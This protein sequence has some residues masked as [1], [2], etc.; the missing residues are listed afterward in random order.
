MQQSWATSGLDL[1]LDLPGTRVRAGLEAALREAV[2]SGRLA[3]GTRLPSSRTLAADLRIARNTVADAYGQLVAEGWLAARQG[4]GTVV[5]SAAWLPGTPAAATAPAA[6]PEAAG[7]PAS[8]IRYDLRA[9][10][11]DLSGFPR[12]AWLAAARKALNASPAQ[13]L[14]YSDPRGLPGLRA[15]LAVY[16][17]RA[18]GVRVAPDRILVCSGFTQGLGL[19]C[20]ALHQQGATSIAV[21]GYGQPGNLDI[22]AGNG[23]RPV[24]LPVD[25]DGAVPD[26]AGDAQAMLLT[27]AHQFPLGPALAARRRAQAARWATVTGGLI[28]EDD[29]DGEFR[30]DRQPVGA[31]QA[32]APEQVAYA[33][34]ASKTLA[35]GLRLGW[36]AL[37]ARIA[38]D[39]TAAKARADAH[40]SSVEQL[41]LAEFIDSGRY[42]RHI[43][44]SRLTYR[45]RRDRLV[46]ELARHA[47]AVRLTGVAAGLHV[48]AELPEGRSESQVTGRAAR[49]GLAVEGLGGYALGGNSR[50]PA[51][52]IGYAT[53]PEHAF[54]GAVARLC[55]AIAG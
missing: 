8:R 45:R 41:A 37:P 25:E 23:L 29:Y 40:T 53:P 34:T 39:V 52:V 42:D 20:Q 15:S 33:G 6:S 16:L 3:A 11:P 5:A 38:G 18:R 21:E 48:V 44:R 55:A 43:R 50:G 49:G 9:G 46:S 36:L 14:G 10:R 28:I 12:A 1:H 35:P 4:S 30:Y 31:L 54:T 51:L 19:L 47:P 2:R 7:V 13:V 24:M 26:A 27:P 22:I 32:L 17:A